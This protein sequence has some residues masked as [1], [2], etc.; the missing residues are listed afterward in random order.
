VGAAPP[1]VRALVMK[2]DGSI[3]AQTASITA[4]DPGR[5]DRLENFGT[6][7]LDAEAG[8]SPLNG[9]SHVRLEIALQNWQDAPAGPGLFVVAVEGNGPIDL[10]V[11]SPPEQPAPVSFDPDGALQ[12][13]TAIRGDTTH[14]V[15]DPATAVS[16]VAVS[17]FTTRTEFPAQNGRNG[18][19]GGALG[20]IASFSSY[21]PTLA[22]ERTGAKPD[23]AAPGYVIVAAR[24]RQGAEDDQGAVSPLY[25]A[26]AGTSMAT[27][28]VAGVAALILDAKPTAT[29]F[30]L[31]Q[32]LLSSAKKDD[33]VKTNDARWGAGKLDAQEALALA[34][35]LEE[36]CACTSF[37]RVRAGS[38]ILWISAIF[39]LA[40]RAK[41]PRVT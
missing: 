41:R 32:I 6:V 11:D 39:L 30:D 4:G 8:P 2:P 35:G 34:L 20:A 33:D 24:S 23:L 1:I 15:S 38:G 27:P 10:W 19:V 28:H 9:K 37:E 29:K 14:S 22:P 26:S 12:I 40:L 7:M 13:A 25:R 18:K 3:L 31:K 21:G 36:G 17:A 5:T 16:A